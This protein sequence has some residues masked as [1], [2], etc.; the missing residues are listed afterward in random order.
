MVWVA[1]GYI[2]SLRLNEYILKIQETQVGLTNER[3]EVF[4][5]ISPLPSII[6]CASIPQF[7][8]L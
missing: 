3:V 1:Q 6:H 2:F 4:T 7:L 5:Q 8:V